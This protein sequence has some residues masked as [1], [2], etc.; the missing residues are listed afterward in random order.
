MSIEDHRAVSITR[1]SVPQVDGHYQVFLPWH[2]IPFCL[3][4]NKS[5]AKKRLKLL[6]RQLSCDEQLRQ[7][8]PNVIDDYLAKGHAR[9]ISKAE[10]DTSG[11]PLCY[12][13]HHPKLHAKKPGKVRTTFDCS[14]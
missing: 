13:P 6:Q 4:K 8:Y 11:K 5:Q 1:K 12:R 3:P 2:D 14:A 9:R 7:I 10:I